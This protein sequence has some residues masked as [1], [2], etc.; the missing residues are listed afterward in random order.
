MPGVRLRLLIPLLV[1][2]AFALIP[3]AANAQWEDRHPT[4]AT[5]TCTPSLIEGQT[6]SEDCP[7][8][9]EDRIASYDD[10]L[11]PTAPTGS[12]EV[13]GVPVC[14]LVPSGETTSG[15][16]YTTTAV[17][18]TTFPLEILYSGDE[19]HQGTLTFIDVW[20]PGYPDYPPEIPAKAP[21]PPP[22]IVPPGWPGD[23]QGEAVGPRIVSTPQ[24]LTREHQAIFRFAGGDRYECAL[25]QGRFRPSGASFSRRVSTGSH[26]LRVREEKGGHAVV[27]HWRVLPGR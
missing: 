12:L 17:W 6:Y 22:G 1:V 16:D 23:P 24:K 5:T 8:T 14:T 10:S 11:I 25:D 19:T 20:G 26:A 3:G 4:L 27:F 21:P 2:A 15:C 18:N 13:N 9:V 7:I